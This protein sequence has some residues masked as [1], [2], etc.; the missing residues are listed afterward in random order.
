MNDT[1]QPRTCRYYRF[2]LLSNLPLSCRTGAGVRQHKQG[3][4]FLLRLAFFLPARRDRRRRR[5]RSLVCLSV[6]LRS[7]SRSP[8]RCRWWCAAHYMM[9]LAR[10][11]RDDRTRP[12]CR[13]ARQGWERRVREC[14]RWRWRC[15][16]RP[17]NMRCRNVAT[18]TAAAIGVASTTTTTTTTSTDAYGGCRPRRVSPGLFAEIWR[19][20]RRWGLWQLL[21][22][23]R[24]RS[25]RREA[26]AAFNRLRDAVPH[27]SLHAPRRG[28]AG[29]RGV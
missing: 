26:R 7:S 25:E 18:A 27:S 15:G 13:R 22:L 4:L 9:Q 8:R 21:G 12:R 14:R 28:T 10:A 2:C 3:R 24:R 17:C 19:G 11:C 16:R 1:P 23:M 6:V 20:S 29:R 5:S